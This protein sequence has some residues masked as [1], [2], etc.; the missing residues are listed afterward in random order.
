MITKHTAAARLTAGLTLAAALTGCAPLLLGGAVLGGGM[1]AT[2]RRTTGTQVEDQ[3]IEIRAA[4][5]VRDLATLGHVN[6]TSYNRV[7]LLTGEVPGETERAGIEAAVARIENVKTVVNEV[8]ITGNSSFGSR[9]NDAVLAAKVKATLVDTKDVQ[10]HAYKV[11]AE[12]GIVYLMGRVT[13]REAV[14]GAAVASSVGGVQKVVR[15]FD[16]LTEE[17]LGGLGRSAAADPAPTAI[18]PK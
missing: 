1:V 14:R 18:A 9:S 17:E 10:A 6:A 7:L 13:E 16:I 11:V 12:R 3:S 4:S 2:D 5:R 8:A 15:V